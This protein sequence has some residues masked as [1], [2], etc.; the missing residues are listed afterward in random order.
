MKLLIVGWYNLINPIIT[1]KDYFT[2]LGYDVY[3]L[4]LLYYNQ[5]Y[6][7][8]QL[9]NALITF[10][11]NIDPAVMLWWNWETRREVLLEIKIKTQNILHVLFNWDHPFCLSSWDNNHNRKITSKNIWDIC[12]ATADYKLDEYINS[13]SSEAYYLRMFADEEIHFPKID[14]SYECDVSFICTNLYEDKV[15]FPNN[16]TNRREVIK[17]IINNGF[18][19]HIYGP[20]NLKEIFPNQYKGFSHFLNNHKV[21][22]NSKINLCTHGD[23]GYKY[24]NERVGTILSSGGLMLC[25][26]VDGIETI[27][28]N[29]KDFILFDENNYIEQI[30]DILNNYD[31]YEYIKDNAVITARNKFSPKYWSEFID[32]KIK[33][34]L[35][36]NSNKGF[37]LKKIYD[38]NNY[39]NKKVSIILT[40]YNR[41]QQLLHTLETIQE[42]TYPKEL[43][44]VICYDDRSDKEPCIIDLSKYTYNIKIVYANFERN[45]DIIN[46]GYSYNN[47]FKYINGEYVIMQ[48]SECMHIG[49]IITYIS[50][51]LKENTL[52]SLQCWATGNEDISLEMFNNRHNSLELER[53][54]STRWHELKDFP[55]KLKGWYNEKIL[56]PECLHFC[57][58]IHINTLKKVGLFDTKIEKLQGFDDH[59]YVQRMIFNYNLDVII[60]EHNYNLFVVHQNHEKYNKERPY[61]LFLH[62]YNEYRKINNRRINSYNNSKIEKIDNIIYKKYNEIEK[63]KF[64]EQLENEYST[65]FVYLIIYENDNIDYK[66]IRNCIKHSNFRVQKN[67]I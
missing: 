4:P 62:S 65:Y 64:L 2:I 48:N 36:K 9:S 26:K 66:F 8:E 25:D 11:K 24:C 34:Y 54:I 23:N 47:A 27:L 44:E 19:V 63:N 39:Q 6:K 57:N 21:F 60:P 52:I 32:L 43:I 18:N 49:D 67:N 56:R 1:A 13:G 20:E 16:I 35:Q 29:N 59:D 37:S 40:H 31:K 46:P 41:K 53:I 28:T 22:Y 17:N 10:I 38:F 45:E 7:G 61:K 51:N 14:K 15:M 50:M 33:N 5:K 55:K 12:F 3:F 58:A 42:S 30:R